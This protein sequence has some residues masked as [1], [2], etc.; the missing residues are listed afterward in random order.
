MR[1]AT[2]LIYE[3]RL[4]TNKLEIW[5]YLREKDLWFVT[6]QGATNLIGGPGAKH[7]QKPNTPQTGEVGSLGTPLEQESQRLLPL[8]SSC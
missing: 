7:Q 1:G 3:A 2:T 5:N 8:P 4:R 6:N